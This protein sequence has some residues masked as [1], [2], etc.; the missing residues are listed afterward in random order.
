[1]Q[2]TFCHQSS[3]Y[4]TI[5]S[6]STVYIG[7]HS[8]ISCCSFIQAH[9]QQ[10]QTYSSMS[11]TNWVNRWYN[12][13]L[14]NIFSHRDL[15]YGYMIIPAG[16]GVFCCYF[17]WCKPAI[18]ACWPFQS[19]SMQYTIVDDDVEAAPIWGSNGKAGQ[20]VIRPHENQ[21]LH[22]KWEPTWME[23]QQKQQVPSKAIPKPR[24]L[25]TNTQNPGNSMSTH[26][27]L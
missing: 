26:G 21:D 10:Q 20:P 8:Y 3:E 13:H 23:S 17:F 14:D 1:M 9:D 25:D 22:M 18:L 2:W 11:T 7:W 12:I 19:G 16:L 5:W 27:L 6:I 4:G 24:S 15:Y